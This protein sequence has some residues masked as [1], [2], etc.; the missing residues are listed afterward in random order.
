MNYEVVFFSV[1]IRH[2]DDYSPEYTM[3]YFRSNALA[4][5]ACVHRG[6]ALL[7]AIFIGF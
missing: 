3:P 5:V 2:S 7:N 4:L 6:G 1:C